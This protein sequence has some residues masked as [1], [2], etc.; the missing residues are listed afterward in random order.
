MNVCNAFTMFVKPAINAR[1]SGVEAS[2]L[3]GS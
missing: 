3:T 1:H 2:R